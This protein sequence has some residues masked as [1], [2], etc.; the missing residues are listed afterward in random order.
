MVHNNDTAYVLYTYKSASGLPFYA[1]TNKA[2]KEPLLRMVE[3][4]RDYS[5]KL[6]HDFRPNVKVY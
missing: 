6:F 2:H 4:G 5:V 1:S 3:K